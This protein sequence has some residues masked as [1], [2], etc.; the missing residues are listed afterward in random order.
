ML[1]DVSHELK[2]PLTSIRAYIETLQIPE[3]AGDPER[4]D[5]Y[6]GT[7]AQETRRLD[8]IVSDLLDL[9]RYENG[10]GTLEPRVFSIERLFQQVAAR[11]ERDADARAVT[12]ST[13]VSDT[14]DQVC[15]DPHRI[16]QVI[17]NLTANALRHTPTGGRI[18]L[19]ARRAGDDVLLAVADTG[20][21]IAPEHLPHVF[22]RFYKVDPSRP[23]GP[24]G[25]GLGLSIVKAVVERH[26]GTVRVTSVPGATEFTVALPQGSP[27]LAADQPTSANL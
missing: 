22:D 19:S 17:D 12:I 26:G 13:N 23:G 16:D 2:T 20:E 8:R 11:H 14:A 24:A 4:R 7:I 9:A 21:G 5:R 10:A 15:A 27:P 3:I 6:F 25:S 18:T 1:A